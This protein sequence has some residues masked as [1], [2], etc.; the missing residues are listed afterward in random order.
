MTIDEQHRM[1][2]SLRAHRG[3][4]NREENAAFDMF[5]KRDKDDE[6]LD[7]TSL[8]TLNLLY[9]KHVAKHSREE[10]EARWKKLTGEV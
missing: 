6:E 1:I 7:T 9:Q 8:R 10:L 5:L 2:A 3:G 4:M